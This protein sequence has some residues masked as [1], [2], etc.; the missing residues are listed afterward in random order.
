MAA[1]PIP[2]IL[3]MAGPGFAPA[4]PD[5]TQVGPEA[6]TLSANAR[7]VGSTASVAIDVAWSRSDLWPDGP[8]GHIQDMIVVTIDEQQVGSPQPI[9]TYAA[10]FTWSVTDYP[11]GNPGS[12]ATHD[13]GPAGSFTPPGWEATGDGYVLVT[14]SDALQAGHTYHIVGESPSDPRARRVWVEYQHGD[15][16]AKHVEVVCNP[17]PAATRAKS[18]RGA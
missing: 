12:P 1:M 14:A 4:I 15:R 3:A 8:F 10:Q 9:G 7:C 2:L 11:P 6:L 5:P 17:S 13:V 16:F 18:E